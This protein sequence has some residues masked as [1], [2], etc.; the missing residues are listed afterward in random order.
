MKKKKKEVEAGQHLCPREG[1]KVK[2][3]LWLLGRPLTVETSRTG[4]ELQNL[5]G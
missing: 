2:G 5:R 1:A 3:R 4:K